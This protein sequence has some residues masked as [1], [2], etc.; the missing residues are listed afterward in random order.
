MKIHKK[1]L[2]LRK[3]KGNIIGDRN[4]LYRSVQLSRG[5]GCHHAMHPGTGCLPWV[6]SN[7]SAQDSQK[8]S[9]IVQRVSIPLNYSTWKWR[10]HGR[11]QTR[12][13]V[14]CQQM[15]MTRHWVKLLKPETVLEPC[16]WTGG[17]A[18][19]LWQRL[20]R[21]ARRQRC[22]NVCAVRRRCH[23]S[24]A[25][26]GHI[27]AEL[28]VYSDFLVSWERKA[29]VWMQTSQADSAAC[30][31]QLLD[32][33]LPGQSP[34]EGAPP[35][36]CPW[37][38]LYPEQV[39]LLAG[40]LFSLTRTRGGPG[41]KSLLPHNAPHFSPIFLSSAFL[42]IPRCHVSVTLSSPS[43]LHCGKVQKGCI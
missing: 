6:N 33:L 14:K 40:V 39:T 17:A 41:K 37:H 10:A 43:Q 24:D 8:I 2:L 22:G 11:D 12:S 18:S 29:G 42:N 28:F 13:C 16:C 36:S 19:E 20:N 38:Y 15:A 23:S 34:W 7:A 4:S 32:P 27:S 5:D 30:P 9:V 1:M 31:H 21:W 26:L 3:Q 35:N 25:A